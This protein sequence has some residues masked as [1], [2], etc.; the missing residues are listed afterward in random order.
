MFQIN[1]H[2]TLNENIADNGGIK[3]AFKVSHLTN[4]SSVITDS[5]LKNVS[6]D[7]HTT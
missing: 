1:G 6:Y 2:Q 3:L 5:N 7:D 4:E